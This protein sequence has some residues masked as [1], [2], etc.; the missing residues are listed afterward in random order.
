LHKF[1]IDV[2]KIDRSFIQGMEADSEK[3]EI[4][5][6]ILGL[7]HNLNMV[8]TAEGIETI[9]QAEILRDLGCDYGQGYLFSHPL[10][11]A[12]ITDVLNPV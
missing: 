9:E 11:S 12:T 3:L 1:P 7:C 5:R 4:V 8:V 6:A 2:V 10:D